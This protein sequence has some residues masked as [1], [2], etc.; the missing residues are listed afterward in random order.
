MGYKDVQII[1]RLDIS[2]TEDENR[3]TNHVKFFDTSGK[4]IYE[5]PLNESRLVYAKRDIRMGKGFYRNGELVNEPFDFSKK[6][7]MTLKTLHNIVRSVM[8]PD[9]VSKKQRFK[10][11]K[12][13]HEFLQKYMSI[14]P[15]Q[16]DIGIYKTDEYWDNYVKYLYHS[17]SKE[18]RQEGLQVFNKV[19][20]AYG[21][22]IDAAYFKDE[23]A[24]VEFLLSAI[25]HCNSDQVFNDDKYDYVTVGLPFMSY[26]GRLI[27]QHELDRNQK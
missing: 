1:H 24:G 14:G 4:L 7:R 8:F 5:K 27:Y 18:S 21:F 9:A 2:L 23:K 3:H 12:E 11:T 20:K 10:L 22:L 26:L 25:I 17:G 19:G 6:N 13:D 16:S 15:P